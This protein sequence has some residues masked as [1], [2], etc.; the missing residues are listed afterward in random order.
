MVGRFLGQLISEFGKLR[1][2][3]KR[4][5]ET[6]GTRRNQGSETKITW[7]TP[8]VAEMAL[9]FIFEHNLQ[10]VGIEKDLYECQ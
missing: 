9:F 7:R 4:T 8:L 1:W 2:P 6:L 3:T 5:F 10:W